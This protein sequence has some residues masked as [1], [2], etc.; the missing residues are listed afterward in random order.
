MLQLMPELLGGSRGSGSSVGGLGSVGRSGGRSRGGFGSGS[1]RGRGGGGSGSSRGRSGFSGL[2]A[3]GNG[4]GNEGSDEK[5]LLHL[6]SF[7]DN[8]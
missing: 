1:S 4:Q 8:G 3:S 2:A 7:I 6:I 5:R